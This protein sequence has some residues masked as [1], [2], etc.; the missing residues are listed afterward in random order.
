MSAST[1]GTTALPETRHFPGHCTLEVALKT[2]VDVYHRYSTREG[3]PDLLSFN[4]FEALLTEQAPTFLQ[5]CNRK[6]PNYLRNLFKETDLNKDREVAFEEFTM[7]LAKLSDDAHRLIH[8]QD[9]C[10]PDKP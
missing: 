10:T 9:R 2:V 5:A 6:N 7:V 3:K 8:H 4:D 1:Q